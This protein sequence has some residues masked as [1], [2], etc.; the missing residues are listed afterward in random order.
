MYDFGGSAPHVKTPSMDGQAKVTNKNRET[1]KAGCVVVNTKGEVLLV[2]ERQRVKWEFPK[3]H[4]EPGETLEHA[5]MREVAEE[6]GY[7]V[8]IARRLPD[9]TYLH[10]HT[11]EPI[12][13]AIFEA[14]PLGVVQPAEEQIES[15]WFS[16]EAA[17]SALY[18]DDMKFL[19]GEIKTQK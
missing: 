11:G 12:R 14:K 15:R 9:V 17:R 5:A 7:A 18:Y 16:I 8:E 10:G 13:V 19:L 4:V 6:T 3:G 1:L 2:T